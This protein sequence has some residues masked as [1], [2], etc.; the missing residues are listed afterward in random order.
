MNGETDGTDRAQR[1]PIAVPIHFRK[2]GMPHWV[3]ERTVNISRT[4]IVF[5]AEEDIPAMP[6]LDVRVDFPARASLDCRCAACGEH[7]RYL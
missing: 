4:G 7:G 5:H 2:S 6:L 3:Q 1:F